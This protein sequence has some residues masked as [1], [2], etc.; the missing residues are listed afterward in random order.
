VWLLVRLWNHA[1]APD[2]P[3]VIDLTRRAV[4]PRPVSDRPSRDAFIVGVRDLVVLAVILEGFLGPRLLDY[5]QRLL[6][7]TSIVV[8]DRG[9]I[10][11]R[12]G[13]MILLPEDVDPAVLV[14]AGEPGV[15]SALGEM[16][17]HREFLCAADRIP[18]RQDEAKRGEPNPLR[19]CCEIGVEHQRRDGTFVAFGVEMMLRGR[20]DVEAGIVCEYRELPQLIEHH[21]VAIVVP[22]DGAQALPFLKRSRNGG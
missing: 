11:R 12:T 22:A 5:L 8:V 3:F 4:L 14:A 18:G 7:D 6:V 17:E 9:T 16:V 21:L 19:A 20:Q 1:D 15:D 2:H 10:H 13:N